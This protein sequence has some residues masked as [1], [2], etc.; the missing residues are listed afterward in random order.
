[1]AQSCSE[2]T[3]LLVTLYII[4]ILPLNFLQPPTLLTNLQRGNTQTEIPQLYGGS[5]IT[6]HTLAGQG[7]LTPEHIHS[8]ILAFLRNNYSP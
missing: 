4:G 3:D 2:S 1:M 5:D 6:F 8:S 7:E